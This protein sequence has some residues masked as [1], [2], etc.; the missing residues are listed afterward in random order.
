MAQELYF[1]PASR[2]LATGADG[3]MMDLDENL[4]K[5]TDYVITGT[6]GLAVIAV[7]LLVFGLGRNPTIRWFSFIVMG[8]AVVLLGI[9][10]TSGST[11]IL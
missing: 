8:T 2:A 10:F 6:L 1:V 7:I 9:K 11:G 3:G 4:L 5:L